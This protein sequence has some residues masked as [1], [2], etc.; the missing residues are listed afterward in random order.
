M[1]ETAALT[2]TP[3]AAAWI[4]KQQDPGRAGS[5]RRPR[6]PGWKSAIVFPSGSLKH[7]E[8]PTGVVSAWSTILKSPNSTKSNSA[9]RLTS[10]R[11]S[12]ATSVHQKRTCVWS[13]GLVTDARRSGASCRPGPRTANGSEPS[14]AR[15]SDRPSPRRTRGCVPGRSSRRPPRSCSERPTF[16]LLGLR[17]VRRRILRSASTTSTPIP[18]A[19]HYPSSTADATRR[20]RRRWASSR[21]ALGAGCRA[22]RLPLDGPPSPLWGAMN[23]APG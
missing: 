2:A 10:S 20:D 5:A 18:Y 1:H 19:R 7:A 6:Y 22:R 13:P 11:T 21:R 14:R 8:L 15:G 17:S 3:D 9:P 12:A 23:D 16:R 4:E